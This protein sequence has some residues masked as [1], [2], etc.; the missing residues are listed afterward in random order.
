MQLKAG[1]E[2]LWEERLRRDIAPIYRLLGCSRGRHRD[3]ELL[4]DDLVGS[5]LGDDYPEMA[6]CEVCGR[7]IAWPN[8][9]PTLVRRESE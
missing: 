2:L 5:D 3:A 4:A 1:W 9:M 7:A 6:I 8:G